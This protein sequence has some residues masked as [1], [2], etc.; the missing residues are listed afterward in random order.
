M[1]EAPWLEA[2]VGFTARFLHHAVSRCGGGNAFTCRLAVVTHAPCTRASCAPGV[3]LPAYTV[4]IAP[5]SRRRL[6]IIKMLL[7]EA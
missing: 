5:W 1:T 6:K 3:V 2:C 4:P 7:L